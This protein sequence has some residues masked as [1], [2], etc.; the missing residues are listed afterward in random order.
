MTFSPEKNIQCV[1]VEIRIQTRSN[2][3]GKKSF[4]ILTSNETVINPK[5]VILKPR[6]LYH[7]YLQSSGSSKIRNLVK[8]SYSFRGIVLLSLFWMFLLTTTIPTL[9]SLESTVRK[10]LQAFLHRTPTKS[11]LIRTLVDRTYKI[12]H[13]WL[14]FQEES[15]SHPFNSEGS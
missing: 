12:K 6:I 13:S 1:S 3:R 5:I 15:F 2:C 11:S 9:L 10:P 7:L 4:T 8:E 14:G